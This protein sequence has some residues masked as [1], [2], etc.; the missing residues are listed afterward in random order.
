[1]NFNIFGMPMTGS[2]ICGFKAN[3]TEEMCS[4]WMQLGLLY[5]FS[6]NHAEN[7]TIHQE[8]WALGPTLLQTARISM[9]LKY[10]ILKYYYS[11]V[12]SK[13]RTGTI[14]RPMFFEYPDDLVA[15]N[16]TL[17]YMDTQFMIGRALLAVPVLAQGQTTVD[18]YLPGDRWFDYFTGEVMKTQNSEGSVIE[19]F[20][21]P[22]NSTIPLFL[23]GGFV[24]QQQN[25][26]G[27]MRSDD[28]DSNFTLLISLIETGENQ[29]VSQGQII[30]TTDYNDTNIFPMCVES[31]CLISIN[32]TA[33]TSTL[34]NYAQ[35]TFNQQNPDAELDAMAIQRFRV[36]G[37]FSDDG[38]INDGFMISDQTMVVQLFLNGNLI[39]SSVQEVDPY[40]VVDLTLKTPVLMKPGDTA[41][42]V[43]YQL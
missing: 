37:W 29:F 22:L 27:V 34:K 10:S 32:V 1:M 41:M 38:F 36:Y 5:P 15:L 42:L 7:D 19:N 35:I 26:T 30:G 28:L 33:T 8:P 17:G 16:S 40:G 11:V 23:R 9:N 20:P 12:I 25:T 21:A 39:Q 3:A 13:N 2:D 6:R 31:N 43:T 18:A 4:R 24:V 14:F